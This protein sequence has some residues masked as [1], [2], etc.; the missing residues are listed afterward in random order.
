LAEAA[1]LPENWIWRDGPVAPGPAAVFDLDGVLSDAAGRQHFLLG[2]GRKDWKSFF[3]HVGSDPLVEDVNRLL[4]LLDER[5]A[6]VLLSARPA[7]VRAATMAWLERHDIRWD[8]LVMRPDGAQESA[9]DFKRTVVELLQ[10]VGF[11]LRIAFE[12][13]RRNVE[14]FRAKGVACVYIHSGYYE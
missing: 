2:T 5:L 4:E 12:D 14:M 13:D 6:I 7:R 8:L 11:D 9:V 3:D 1:A 10:R